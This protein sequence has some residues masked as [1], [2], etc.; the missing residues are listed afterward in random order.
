ML[1]TALQR[2]Q[3]LAP[4]E[5]RLVSV[6]AML[7][8]LYAFFALLIEP[9][10]NRRAT[11]DQ[12]LPRLRAQLAQVEQLAHEAQR[13]SQAA[14]QRDTADTVRLRLERSIEQAGLKPHLGR[15]DMGDT[16]VEIAFQGVPHA[17][18]LGWLEAVLR[19]SRLRVVDVGLVRDPR[20]G[21]VVARLV[22]EMPGV[23]R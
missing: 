14:G 21:R 10:W 7:V 2:W 16:L 13:L 18:W 23:R 11:L 19:E 12:E 20:P 15:L 6:A 4:R 5:R 3:S 17:Q 9:A 22:L 8:G 1:E